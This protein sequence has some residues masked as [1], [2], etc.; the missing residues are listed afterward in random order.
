[1]LIYLLLVA[2]CWSCQK[3]DN[4]QTKMNESTSLQ[5]TQWK[6]ISFVDTETGVSKEAESKDKRSYT[7]RFND[8]NTLGGFS[9]T[10]ELDGSYEPDY[11]TND[12]N[13]TI[14][15]R[16]FIN[17]LLDGNKY[18]DLLNNIQS[19]SLEKNELRLYYADKKN[20]LL[21]KPQL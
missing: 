21:F 9:S 10:N 3:N 18:V 14:G 5:G 1:M 16:T 6:L 13:I 4:G 8:D 15:Q 2:V 12:I 20:Y 11:S 17:E 19:F 7:L